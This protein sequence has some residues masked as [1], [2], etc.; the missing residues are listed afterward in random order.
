[1]FTNLP[2]TQNCVNTEQVTNYST[3]GM[4]V[5]GTESHMQQKGK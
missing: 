2:P 1:M 5:S 4:A 3:Y